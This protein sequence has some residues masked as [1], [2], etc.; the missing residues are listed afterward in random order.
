MQGLQ[1]DMYV[2]VPNGKLAPVHLHCLVYECDGYVECMEG[3]TPTQFQQLVTS[4]VAKV[5][6]PLNGSVTCTVA[7]LSSAHKYSM[8]AARAKQQPKPA[9]NMNLDILENII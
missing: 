4:N 5:K 1:F 7:D 6:E 9:P 3:V 8:Q 2:S